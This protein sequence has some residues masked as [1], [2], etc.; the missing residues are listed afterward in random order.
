MNHPL[1]PGTRGGSPGG[2]EIRQLPHS[3]IGAFRQAGGQG[4]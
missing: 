2:S 3:Y 1:N 4:Q